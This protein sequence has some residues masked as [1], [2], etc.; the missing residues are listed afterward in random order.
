MSQRSLI[1]TALALLAIALYAIGFHT[2]IYVILGLA[3]AMEL[4]FWYK[5]LLEKN[6]HKSDQ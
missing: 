2:G 3:I 6:K 5:F 1:L 4:W